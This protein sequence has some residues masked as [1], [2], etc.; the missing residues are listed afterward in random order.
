MKERILKRLLCEFLSVMVVALAFPDAGFSSQGLKPQF[1]VAT[2]ST[3][4]PLLQK[5]QGAGA[6][7][8]G[9]ANREHTWLLDPEVFG[10][11]SSAG[12][13]A[14]LRVNGL[15][16]PA[17]SR[18]PRLQK[19]PAVSA[20]LAP[21]ENVRVNNPALDE[22]GHTQ[23]ESS[24]AV[25]GANIA[26]SF[27]DASQDGSGLAISTDSGAT[28]T[29]KRIPVIAGGANLGDGVV[30]F[31]PS[32]ELY[33]S[34]LAFTGQGQSIVG[35]AT[36]VD[37]G[38]NFS[39]PANVSGVL[40]NRTDFQDKPWVTADR[41]AASPFRGNVYA[42]W[43]DFTQSGGSFI[44]F[45]R[46]G[47]GG[48]SFSN[49]IQL[50]P[51]DGT[52]LV[53]GS[54]PAVA[55]NGD[56]YV[57][58]LDAHPPNRT[59]GITVLRSTNGGQSFGPPVT[60]AAFV[61]IGTVT[62]GGGVRTNSFPSIAVDNNGNVHI[63]YAG[64]PTPTGAD[65]SNVFYVRSTDNGA[66]FSPASRLNDDGTTTSQ[67]FPFVAVAGDNTIGVKW[68]DRRNDPLGDSL[69]DMYMTKSSDGGVTFSKNFRLTNQNWVAGPIE[70]GF[71]AGYHGDYDGMTGD[72]ANFFGSWSD[73]RGGDP[74]VYITQIPT[75]R[76]ANDPDF[77]ISTRK[78]FDG[79]LAGNAVDFDLDTSPAN[80]F[81]GSLALSASS[82]TAGL[83]FTFA[84]PAV[85][86][87]QAARLTVSTSAATAPGTYLVAVSAASGA[88]FRKTTLRVGVY[89]ASRD[90]SLPVNISNTNGF[91]KSLS[92]VLADAAGMVHFVY[93]DDV[94]FGGR[95]TPS[96]FY[97][98]SSDGG[99]TFTAPLKINGDHVLS[100]NSVFALDPAG[101][102]HVAWIGFDGTFQA[103]AFY[104]MSSDGGQSFSTPINVAAAG[105]FPELLAIAVDGNGDVLLAYT[106]FSLQNPRVF[107]ARSNNSGASFGGPEMV[108]QANDTTNTFP[109]SAAL[110]SHGNGYVLYN[111]GLG[112]STAI[113]VNFARAAAGQN[114][115]A[116]R[117]LTPTATP[118]FAPHAA[119]DASDNLFVTFY[120]RFG[121]S[122]INR[123]VILIKSTDGGV[124]FSG[125]QNLSNNLG[126][127]TI[128]HIIQG[129]AN[130]AVVWQ[131]TTDNDQSD[132]FALRSTDN[133]ASFSAVV[134][135]SAN[136]GQSTGPT[137]TYDASGNLLIAWLDDSTANPEI[138]L[139][140]GGAAGI[141]PAPD[142]TL[143][144]P[145]P[146]LDI[147]RGT[148]GDIVVNIMR[149]GGF[150][151]NVTVTPSNPGGKIKVP[152][153][154]LST[155]GNSVSFR[156]KAKAG[157]AIGPRPITFSASDGAGHV[158]TATLTLNVQ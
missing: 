11:L 52:Q 79:V 99:R 157:A 100:A 58:F 27:N 112:S 13:R 129:G 68:W 20:E 84:N 82:S 69:T 30:V 139:A 134:N 83:T 19:S 102:I 16:E 22:D 9:A 128:P 67:F 148:K 156:Y 101:R 145:S 1:P 62:G 124:S 59:G 142:Y 127:S 64:I 121:T 137:G 43:T 122:T 10:H 8:S 34:T 149:V 74:D 94:G 87:G 153:D 72:A 49:P 65:R 42:S 107:A 41:G 123:D 95:G 28:F 118:A 33:Y 151:A 104:T 24:V 115:A 133:G 138:L 40:S 105:H 132:V 77:N 4:G 66:S 85:N 31:G 109:V 89:P 36:S 119:V 114:F 144:F 71:A 15:L 53:Q 63:V 143:G 93:D 125:Q 51:R 3:N 60:A 48:S 18:Q 35:L 135:V 96:V 56:V 57:A 73:E 88:L 76:N 117:A 45:A 32:G 116:P 110:D 47:P 106:D 23:S 2:G 155:T 86:A 98:R 55:P 113:T 81:A 17:A 97:K 7:S 126:Q 26:V 54:M 120:D 14:V 78:P 37:G 140:S 29:H 154:P 90:F 44:V 111:G 130:L 38:A 91:T 152:L 61:S 46:S 141:P 103:G 150:S 6:P 146:T 70:A 25:N 108:S 131:D 5:E 158:R 21:G 80:G 147:Q 12:K 92:G 39:V 136:H 50:S 75:S